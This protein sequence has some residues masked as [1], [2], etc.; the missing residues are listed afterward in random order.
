VVFQLGVRDL[1]PLVEIFFVYF[2]HCLLLN[3]AALIRVSPDAPI[4]YP[5]GPR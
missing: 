1:A 3:F 2:G 4:L 5:G